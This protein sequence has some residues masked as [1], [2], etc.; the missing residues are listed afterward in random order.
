M[1]R[2]LYFSTYQLALYDALQSSG[3]ETLAAVAA[4]A[5]KE[6]SYHRDH[7]DNWVIRLGDGTDESHRRMQAGLDAL[8]PFAGELFE[9]DDLVDALVAEGVAVDPAGLRSTWDEHVDAV[10]AEA[11][12][13]RPT[14]RALAGTARRGVHSEHLGHMLA[15][16]QYVHRMHPGARW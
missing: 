8:L 3:D 16:M 9:T 14:A 11:T 13:T 7:A 2:Q 15:E 10:L 6:V 4:K 5:V 1:A 12:L